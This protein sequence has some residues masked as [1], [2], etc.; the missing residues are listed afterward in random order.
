M[1][2]YS[3]PNRNFRVRKKLYEVANCDADWELIVVVLKLLR[4]ESEIAQRIVQGYDESHIAS[5][6]NLA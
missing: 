6:L 1:D 2:P 4:R 3:Q 5:D